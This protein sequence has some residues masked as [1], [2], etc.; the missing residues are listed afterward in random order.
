LQTQRRRGVE[1]MAQQSGLG[2]RADTEVNFLLPAPVRRLGGWSGL[3]N[4]EQDMI[5][6]APWVRA[7]ERVVAA[8]CLEEF[9]PGGQRVAQQVVVVQAEQHVAE[10]GCRRQGI[11]A[12]PGA[13]RKGLIRKAL[14]QQMAVG[15]E[16][17]L[18]L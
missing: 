4:T 5:G 14:A 1:G 8:G 10:L 16:A 2:L 9:P 15:L 7:A 18:Q 12:L 6:K 17:A 11:Q 13:L 3:R